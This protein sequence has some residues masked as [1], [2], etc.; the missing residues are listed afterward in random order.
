MKNLIILFSLILSQSAFAQ[1]DCD[2]SLNDGTDFQLTLVEKAAG[3]GQMSMRAPEIGL[4]GNC[5]ETGFDFIC[6]T[7]KG[8]QIEIGFQS[9]RF[10]WEKNDGQTV[11]G[12]AICN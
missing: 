9:Q 8:E 11:R 4:Y 3:T 12:L 1:F 6:R 10:I 2:I 7:N 5:N